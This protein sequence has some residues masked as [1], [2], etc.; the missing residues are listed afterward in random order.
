MDASVAH[1]RHIVTGM[2]AGFGDHA[3]ALR[4]VGQQVQRRLK[5]RLEGAQVTVVDADQFDAQRQCTLELFAVMHLDQHIHAQLTRLTIQ[6]AQ[7]RIVQRRNDQ[8][9]AVGADGTRFQHLIRMDDEVL[10]NHRNRDGI[11]R[12]DHE[13]LVPLEEVGIGEHR[14]TGSAG[15]LVGHGDLGGHEVFTD[16]ALGG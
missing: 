14:Q 9:D 7:A 6:S 5:R 2:D 11:T 16:H 8:Q 3:H 1:L 4:H 13:V 10:A 12:L 15:L